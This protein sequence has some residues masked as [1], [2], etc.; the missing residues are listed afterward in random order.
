MQRC[1][2]KFYRICPTDDAVDA[3]SIRIDI[4]LTLRGECRCASY[5][6]LWKTSMTFRPVAYALLCSGQQNL[7]NDLPSNG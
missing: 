7:A 4:S 3:T 6:A 2:P 5:F 1:Q